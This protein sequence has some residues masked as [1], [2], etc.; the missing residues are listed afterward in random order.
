MPSLRCPEQGLSSCPCPSLHSC[1]SS[2]FI[3]S[4][5]GNG[6]AIL[7]LNHASPGL[8]R[9]PG[10]HKLQVASLW[11]QFT[12]AISKRPSL[13]YS[14]PKPRITR[15]LRAGNGQMLFDSRAATIGDLHALACI[16]HIQKPPKI[17]SHDGSSST[18][19]PDPTVPL[20]VACYKQVLG[21]FLAEL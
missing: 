12:Y 18:R 7:R 5:M 21:V 16:V 20:H 6:W 2:L 1:R 10:S 11:P 14:T 8:P 19:V 9:C 3:M 17:H 13:S 15:E 4:Q